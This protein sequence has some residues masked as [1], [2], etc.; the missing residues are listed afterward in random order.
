VVGELTDVSEVCGEVVDELAD[1]L[2]V[3]AVEDVRSTTIVVVLVMSTG[4]VV[5]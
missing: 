2:E 1:V 4:M 5:E 3:C